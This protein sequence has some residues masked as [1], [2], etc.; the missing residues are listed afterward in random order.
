MSDDEISEGGIS[1]GSAP[2]SYISEE[3]EKNPKL[4]NLLGLPKQNESSIEDLQTPD[5]SS[6]KL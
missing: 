1:D 3:L 4:R 2:V 6:K 5:Q